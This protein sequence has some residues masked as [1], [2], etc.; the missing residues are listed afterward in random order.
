MRKSLATA[1]SLTLLFQANGAVGQERGDTTQVIPIEGVTVTVLR[2]PL[3]VR[4]APFAVD[5]NTEAQIQRGRP[6]LGLGE[7]LGGIPGLQVDDRYNYALGDRISIRGFGAR[8][9]FGVRGVNVTVDGI[10]AT[11]PDGNTNLNHVDLSVLSRAEVIRGPASSLYGNAAGGVIQFETEVPGDARLSQEVGVVAGSDGLL[12]LNSTTAGRTEDSYY[13]FNVSRLT[14]DGYRPYQDA[15]NVLLTGSMGTTVFGGD[16]RLV[17]SFVDYDANNP[18]SLNNAQLEEDRFQ[19]APQNLTHQTGEDG[20]QGQMGL[21]WRGLVGPGRLEIA[22]YGL[23]REIM[24]PIPFNTIQIGRNAG[25]VNLLYRSAGDP[26]TSRFGWGFGVEGDLQSDDR[27]NFSHN[28]AG[29]RSETPSIAQ[30]EKVLGGAVFAQ[31][32]A[33]PTP[34][35]IA[36]AGLR[37][38]VT[39]FKADDRLITA[40]DPDDSGERTMDA[41]SPSI[42]LSYA[43]VDNA[44]IYGNVSTSFETPTTTELANQEDG[45]GGFNANLEPQRTLSYEVGLKGILAGRAGYQLAVYRAEIEDALVPFTA[46]NERTYYRNAGSAIHQG[47]EV[48]LTL[49][50]VNFVNVDLSYAYV[51]AR[52]DEYTVDGVS[53]ADNRIPGVS[54]HRVDA[55]VT[56]QS[57]LGLFLT[58]NARYTDLMPV[59]DENTAS[60]PAYTLVDLRTGFDPVS[61]GGFSISPFVGVTNLFDE[62]YITS[63]SVNHASGRFFE[64]GPGRAFYGGGQIRFG[65]R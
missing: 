4:A 28:G 18:G 34:G 41:I 51:D 2:S 48:G 22:G 40:T 19:A 16:F 29:V 7:A 17:G 5:A 6:G 13:L 8:T 33:A 45:S 11:L 49:S 32:T 44:T 59:N 36:L 61:I 30:D 12:R 38:D 55:G 54:P 20:Q 1:L 56:F 47:A 53:R 35:L 63:P 57:P 14:Y 10:P 3:L 58:A 26:A 39:R 9:P 43:V 27:L 23:T 25:G 64:P 62:E 52:F 50:P 21:S 24:N 42:G 65:A 46:P 37:Y 15:R 31:L 60:A